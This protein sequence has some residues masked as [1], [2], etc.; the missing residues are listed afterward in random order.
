MQHQPLG[1]CKVRAE[2][3]ILIENIAKRKSVWGENTDMMNLR[4]IKMTEICPE[5][6]HVHCALIASGASRTQ[7][8]H[9]AGS[10]MDSR[11][12]PGN[13]LTEHITPD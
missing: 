13:C 10:I 2:M 1:E 7:M 6:E 12:H 8:T 3:M 11:E 9:Q 4:A 5:M